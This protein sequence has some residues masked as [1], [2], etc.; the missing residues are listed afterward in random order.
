MGQGPQW[1]SDERSGRPIGGRGHPARGLRSVGRVSAR[2]GQAGGRSCRRTT[3]G[4]RLTPDRDVT[5]ALHAPSADR[6][7]GRS[8][9]VRRGRARPRTDRIGPS[10]TDGDRIGDRRGHRQRPRPRHEPVGRL[11]LVRRSRVELDPDSRPLLRQHPDGR[12][13]HLGHDRRPADGTRQRRDA[14]CGV[15]RR[16]DQRRRGRLDGGHRDRPEHVPG[17]QRGDADLPDRRLQRLDARRRTGRRP[18][19][20]HDERERSRGRESD[21][22]RRTDLG[23]RGVRGSPARSRTTGVRCASRTATG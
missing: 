13:R 18:D 5:V 4:D 15:L 22:V 1:R 10:R 19:R 9:P 6:R 12:R 14:R 20:V 7:R 2:T 8:R 23:A 21:D 16:R 3:R 11:R 17:V